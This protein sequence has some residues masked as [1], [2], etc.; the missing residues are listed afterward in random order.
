MQINN[1][2][3]YFKKYLKYKKKYLDLLDKIGGSFDLPQKLDGLFTKIRTIHNSGSIYGTKFINQC[4]FISIKD[5]LNNNGY[6]NLTLEELRH[7]AGLSGIME[8]Q[9]WNQDN[10]R[11]V[12]AL[13]RLSELYDLDINIWD[14]TRDGL[15]DQRYLSAD[16]LRLNPRYR[17]GEGRTNK[18]NIASF[19]AHF[20][21]IMGG[22]IFFDLPDTPLKSDSTIS[23][24]QPYIL[25][26]DKYIKLDK[27]T[28]NE[29]LKE[30]A[31][32]EIKTLEHIKSIITQDITTTE[33]KRLLELN[34]SNALD[35]RNFE[36]Y[37]K[38]I[39]EAIK[40]QTKE[41]DKKIDNLN[42]L[43]EKINELKEIQKSIEEY[44]ED[45]VILKVISEMNLSKEEILLN[46]KIL[47]KSD[48]IK[49]KNLKDREKKLKD[50]IDKAT[51]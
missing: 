33:E 40:S 38:N 19:G 6:P 1:K 42:I 31:Q 12:L 43:I 48:E 7:Q 3:I 4:M 39:Q 8:R 9:E 34:K 36:I 11:H 46:K 47:K 28:Y 10:H 37:L 50:E 17:E 41:Y 45:P 2:L 29:K 15:L 27:L 14:V 26:D 20:E 18:V 35:D 21:L 32:K 51:I 16:E 24:Y 22:G 23:D 13:Q 44:S 5:Y 25:K 49:L 30:E